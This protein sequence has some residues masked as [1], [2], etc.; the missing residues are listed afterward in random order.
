MK[1]LILLLFVPLFFACQKEHIL[2]AKLGI[3]GDKTM[4]ILHDEDE[5]STDI[6][7]TRRFVRNSYY[8][9]NESGD[10]IFIPIGIPYSTSHLVANIESRS[11][12]KTSV[13]SGFCEKWADGFAPNSHSFAPGDTINIRYTIRIDSNNDE[14]D[15]WLKNISTK[16]LLTKIHI[17]ADSLYA[18]KSRLPIPH[19]VFNNDTSDVNIN[20][21]VR[22]KNNNNTK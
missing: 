8:C 13:V 4:R 2:E 16:E 15:E 3:V 5:D 14:D 12:L 10:S 9:V 19:I 7:S 6:E 20:P 11:S 17:N 22:A 1:K 21:I 18:M